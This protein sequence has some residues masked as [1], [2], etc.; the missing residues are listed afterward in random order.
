KKAVLPY[1][2]IAIIFMFLGSL[3]SNNL[4]WELADMFNQ[5]MVVPN[6]LALLALSGM[7]INELKDATKK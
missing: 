3:L 7:I 4:V 2:I 1:M 6:V 5:L